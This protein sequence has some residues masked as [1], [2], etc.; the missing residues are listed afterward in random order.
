ML[1]NRLLLSLTM[2]AAISSGTLFAMDYVWF[3]GEQPSSQ[4]GGLNDQHPFD[5]QDAKLSGGHSIGGTSRVDTW[6]EY[7][8]EIPKDGEYQ[9]FARKFWNHG[10]FKVRWDGV[11]DWFEVKGT[12]LIDRVTLTQHCITWTT[13]GSATLKKGKHTLR[14][15]A[16]EADKPFVIDCFV[17]V[18]GAFTPNAL[19][20]PG[21]K[22]NLAAPGFWPFEPEADAFTADP[23][24]LRSMNETIAGEKGYVAVDKNGD[25]TYGDGKPLR[26]WGVN[27][28]VQTNYP[29]HEV[30]EHFKHLAKR[31]VNNARFMSNI[32]PDGMDLHAKANASTIDAL[33]KLVAAAKSQGIYTTWSPIWMGHGAPTETT[34]MW[35]E[36]M[37]SAYKRWIKEALTAPNP[38]DVKKIPVGKDPALAVFQIQNE[39]SMFFWT[40]MNAL[41]DDRLVRL[42]KKYHEWREKN[43][44]SGTP[45]LSFKFWECS[46]PSQDMKDTMRFFAELQRAWNTEVERFLRNDCGCKA[47]INPGNWRTADQVHLLD[48][49]RWSYSANEVMGVNRY[50]SGVHVN[51]THPERNGYAVDVGD[52]FTDGSKTVE[53][54]SLATNIRQVTGKAF[55]IPESTWVPPGSHHSEGPFLIAAYSA[56]TGVDTYYWFCLGEIGFDKSVGKW[57]A[58]SPVIMGGWPAASFAL[59]KGLIK[60]G[61]PVLNEHRSKDDL[62]NLRAP[63]LAEESGF[64]PNRDK[65]ISPKSNITSTIKPEAYLVGPVQVT[66][67]SDASKTIAMDLTHFVDEKKHTITSNT[68][69]LVMHTSDGLCTLDAPAAQGATAMALG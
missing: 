41:K 63:L 40:T 31:G 30:V 60:R 32:C 37:Q 22:F 48:L 42:T 35:D 49:E 4:S 55:I 6:L 12:R 25:F 8:V 16:L 39:D 9:L 21:E 26:F 66:F 11:G 65:E 51:P 68:N 36:E 62:W 28:F 54:D 46:N 61:A 27:S 58:A 69:E 19:L 47:V 29:Y 1:T 57:Q 2:T 34:L 10:P 7:Q 38:Y 45:A 52:L 56:L 59:R 14:V 50:V 5:A 3:E 15:E 13:A 18:N 17:A 33:H 23:L 53:W 67:D 24:N 44:L 43:H 20:K 64:D